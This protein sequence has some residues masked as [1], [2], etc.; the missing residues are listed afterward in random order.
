MHR[1]FG[2]IGKTLK[3]SFSKKYFEAK[4]QTENIQNCSY[5]LFELSDISAFEN[6]VSST[7]DLRGLNVTIPYKTEILPYLNRL[8][9]SAQKVGAVNVIKVEDQGLTGYNSD[10]YG[11]LESLRNWLPESNQP[12]KALILGTGGASKAVQAVLIDLNI[13]YN[14]VSRTSSEEILS[15]DELNSNPQLYKEYSLIINTT[16]LGMFPDTNTSPALNYDL[17]TSDHLLYDLVYNPEETLFMQKGLN[18]GSKVKN[19]LEMLH[20]QA[21][22]SWEIWNQEST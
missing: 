19:G 13:E 18:V 2:L 15:Y 6:L 7:K 1:V 22:K 9:T 5:E 4:F 11:F 20:L 12:F 10:Y 14:F 3:H 17:L 8:D 21:E 16:P